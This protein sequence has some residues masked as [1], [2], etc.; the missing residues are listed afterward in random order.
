MAFSLRGWAGFHNLPRGAADTGLPSVST[1][2]VRDHGTHDLAVAMPQT[3]VTHRMRNLDG[4]AAVSISAQARGM[5]ALNTP[6][7]S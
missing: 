4:S 1:T 3:S 7:L 5:W 2:E 6:A